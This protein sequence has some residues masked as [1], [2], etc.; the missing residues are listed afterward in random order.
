METNH[1]SNYIWYFSD[2]SSIQGKEAL[3]YI[4]KRQSVLNELMKYIDS[5]IK[6]MKKFNTDQEIIG[7]DDVDSP[8]AKLITTLENLSIVEL[9]CEAILERLRTRLS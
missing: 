1:Y 4:L 7:D 2:G 3:D 9:C 8:Y 6:Q 5:N